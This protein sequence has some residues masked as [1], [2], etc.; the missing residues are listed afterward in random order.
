MSE[1]NNLPSA[2][3]PNSSSEHPLE[4]ELQSSIHLSEATHSAHQATSLSEPTSSNLSVSEPFL[5]ATQSNPHVTALGMDGDPGDSLNG[6]S[7]DEENEENKEQASSA[8]M[9]LRE[10]TETVVLALII[11]LLMRQVIQNYRIES[12]SMEPNFSEGQFILVNKLSYILGEPSRGDVVVFHNPNNK[13][14]DYIKRVIGLPGDTLHITNQ[15]VFINDTLLDEEYIQY[16]IR[17]GEELGPLVIEPGN[18]F[19]MGDN[20]PNSSDS[21]RFG[22]LS[23][24]LLVG[25]AWLRVWPANRWGLVEHYHEN[26]VVAVP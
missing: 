18:L 4:P 20:R 2:R 24:E 10:V 14:E 13:D 1:S 16:Q 8:W 25:K 9:I 3:S 21:R 6:Q 5:V 17:S 26:T 19:V 22:Q 11:F 15:Q 23:Q 12:H 7:T